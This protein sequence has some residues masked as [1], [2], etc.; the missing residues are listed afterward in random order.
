MIA[1]IAEIAEIA[2]IARHRK[3]F[4][5][6]FAR[7]IADGT[8]SEKLLK[9]R[10]DQRLSAVE[11]LCCF[12]SRAISAITRDHGDF[13]KL[14]TALSQQLFPAMRSYSAVSPIQDIDK[15]RSAAWD[16]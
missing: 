14:P 7:M 15:R 13:Y 12:R 3:A 2:V 6:G 10:V 8:V 5:R 4:N 11:S 9:Y 16:S 1:E